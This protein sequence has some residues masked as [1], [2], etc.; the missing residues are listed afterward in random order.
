L[1]P[2]I[3]EDDLEW[4]LERI[5]IRIDSGMQSRQAYNLTHS[6]FLTQREKNQ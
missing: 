5:A 2:S 4:F 1:Y 3:S 6:D